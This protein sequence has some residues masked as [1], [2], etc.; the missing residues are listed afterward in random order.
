M[1]ASL[2]ISNPS[3]QRLVGPVLVE[4][5]A[6]SAATPDFDA[7]SRGCGVDRPAEHRRLLFP[8]SEGA[9]VGRSGTGAAF[10]V[11]QPWEEA[12]DRVAVTSWEQAPPG[13]DDVAAARTC[14]VQP[15]VALGPQLGDGRHLGMVP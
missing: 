8:L 15:G 10:L 13:D 2:R 14:D 6:D 1:G 3:R 7:L 11:L 5:G 9:H 4:V 12:S